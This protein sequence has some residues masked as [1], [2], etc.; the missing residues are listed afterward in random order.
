[1]SEATL[2]SPTRRPLRAFAVGAIAVAALLVV[3]AALTRPGPAPDIDLPTLSGHPFNPSKLAGKVQVVNFWSTSCSV[4]L[5]EM[6]ALVELHEAYSGRGVAV[7][8]IAMH[9]DSRDRVLAYQVQQQLPFT[10][11]LDPYG[12]AARD[13]GDVR[14][15]PT[16]FVIDRDSRVVARYQGRIDFDELGQR[17]ERLVNG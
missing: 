14:G 12:K 15:T 9:Y 6:P 1:M 10:M 11:A 8:A 4:C 2:S 5:V 17:L 13:F 3:L 16:T 7:T